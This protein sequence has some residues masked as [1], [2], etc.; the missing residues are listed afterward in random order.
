MIYNYAKIINTRSL[1]NPSNKYKYK[2]PCQTSIQKGM[3][4]K[5]NNKVSFGLMRAFINTNIM[6]TVSTV[7]IT[8]IGY[9]LRIHDFSSYGNY[10]YS[11]SWFFLN[12]FSKA[13]IDIFHD[14]FITF[15]STGCAWTM[16]TI[17]TFM[18]GSLVFYGYMALLETD[19]LWAITGANGHKCAHSKDYG[20]Y[21]L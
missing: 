12:L 19:F 9:V 5:L 3:M 20:T 11:H 21:L 15:L 8:K 16:V 4:D 2:I 10:H 1:P 14:T 7:L 17:L 13:S 18:D 6:M